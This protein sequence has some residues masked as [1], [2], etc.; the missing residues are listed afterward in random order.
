[1]SYVQEDGAASKAGIKRGDIIIKVNNNKVDSR[2]EFEEILSYCSPGDQIS[3]TY[4]RNNK[5]YS[6][7][8]VL[9]NKEG[10]TELIHREI[11]TS[12]ALGAELEKVSKVERDL[13]KID[14]GVRIMKISNGL[15]RQMSLSEGFIITHINRIPIKDPETLNDILTKIRGRVTIEGVNKIG[16]K[17]AYRYYF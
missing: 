10:T 8:L 7:Q 12:R 9:T 13:L 5:E 4:K 3:V 16:R 6:R 11:Y 17:Q 15:I 14:H 2:S 1:V